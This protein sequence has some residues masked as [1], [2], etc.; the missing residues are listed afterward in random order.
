MI[1]GGLLGDGTPLYIDGVL[2]GVGFI[3]IPSII[4]SMPK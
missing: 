1:F 4:L 3:A 2:I